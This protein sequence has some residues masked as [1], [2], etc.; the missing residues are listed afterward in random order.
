MK[1]SNLV[2][3][4]RQFRVYHRWVGISIVVFMVATSITGVL[5]GWKK[6]M[7]WLQPPMQKGS[8]NSTA[9]WVSFDQVVRTANRA[10]DSL[11]ITRSG[12]DRL[13]ARPDKGIIKV[14]YQNY[15]EVQ[16]DGA[17]GR[18]LSVAR[19]NADFIEHIHDG[20]IISD[21]VKLVYTNYTGLGL[22]V[23]A[24]SGFW[25]WYGPRRVRAKKE[26]P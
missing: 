16:V 3:S 11:A 25:L 1:L 21:A 20:S 5:L 8:S 12:I 9:N 6:N 13:D 4:I 26:R 17:T 23:L 7:N 24:L 14:I 2:T 15:W 18:A 22:F 10:I 19:R